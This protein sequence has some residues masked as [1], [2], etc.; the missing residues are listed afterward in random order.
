MQDLI[1]YCK[2][3]NLKNVIFVRFPHSK[4]VKDTK[5]IEDVKM[6]VEDNGYDL[7]CL[8]GFYYYLVATE[9]RKNG[10]K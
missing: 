5:S 10:L 7:I 4:E 9:T 1:D 3:E 2:D 8:N 6:L